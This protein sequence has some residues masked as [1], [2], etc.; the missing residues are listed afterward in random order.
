MKKGTVL[1]G[2]IMIVVIVL[3]VVLVVSRDSSDDMMMEE[4]NNEEGRLI[5]DK[6]SEEN[7]MEE[8]GYYEDYSVDKLE[9]ANEGDV[10]LFFH[11]SWCPTCRSLDSD[12][13][14]NSKNI[15]SDVTIL[16]TDYDSETS[17]KQKYGVTYQHTMVQVDADGNMIHKWSGSPTLASLLGNIR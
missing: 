10:V 9:R 2:L 3:G 16:K 6:L 4:S 17:L 13:V 5:E 14:S 12:I 11:A 7:M 8:Y 1:W 15:P